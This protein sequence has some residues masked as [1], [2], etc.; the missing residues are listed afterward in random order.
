MLCLGPF[1]G[2]FR[3]ELGDSSDEEDDESNMRARPKKKKRNQRPKKGGSNAS[4]NILWAAYLSQTRMEVQ[5]RG[6]TQMIQVTQLQVE[7][8]Q[9]LTE[10]ML[11]RVNQLN[12]VYVIEI[13]KCGL[14][15][16]PPS[17]DELENLLVVNLSN[18]QIRK[19]APEL[20]LSTTLEKIV[21]DGNHIQDIPPGIFSGERF[22]NLQVISLSRNRLTALPNDFP[23]TSRPLNLKYV[24]LSRNALKSVPERLMKCRNL[25]ELNLSHNKLRQL[26]ES[27]ELDKLKLLFLSFNEISKLP[28]E[29]GR[30]T[31]MTKLRIVD[32]K[33]REL[34]LSILKLWKK[35]NGKLEELL[36]DRNP[37]SMPSITAFTMEGGASGMDRALHLLEE[38]KQEVEQETNRLKLEAEKA[39]QRAAAAHALDDEIAHQKQLKLEDASEQ[40]EAEEES[41]AHKWYFGGEI[42]KSNE[43]M[44][45]RIREAEQAFLVRKRHSY[46]LQ[47]RNQAE[48]LRLNGY[49]LSEEMESF[50]DHKSFENYRGKIPANEVDLFFALFVFAARTAY[51]SAEMW[52]DKFEV[53]GKHYMTKQEWYEMCLHS[54]LDVR[55]KW[56]DMLWAHVYYPSNDRRGISLEDF[57]AVIHIHDIED[58]DPWITRMAGALHLDYYSLTVSDI[59]GRLRSVNGLDAT[60]QTGEGNE[61]DEDFAEFLAS[62]TTGT[63]LKSLRLK[64]SQN[65]QAVVAIDR[66]SIDM[67]ELLRKVSLTA[68]EHELVQ[69]VDERSDAESSSPEMQAHVSDDEVSEVSE[70]DAQAFLEQH[71]EEMEPASSKAGKQEYTRI[72][73]N[74]DG[75]LKQLMQVP[76]GDFFKG[77][78]ERQRKQLQSLRPIVTSHHKQTVKDLG[79]ELVV[80]QALL[81]AFRNMPFFDFMS[82]VGFVL[83]GLHRAQEDK[84]SAT[85]RYWHEDDPTFRHAM[86]NRGGA[87]SRY[88]LNV[89]TAMG[90]VRMSQ[91]YWIWPSVHLTH[92]EK[93]TTWG[94]LAVPPNCP[95]TRQGRLD[96][97]VSLLT[98]CL[99]ALHSQGHHY[100]G[101]FPS[102]SRA[103][104]TT[105]AV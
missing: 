17:L 36:V 83:R 65:K 95:G 5:V 56:M 86:G 24:D 61:H 15:K 94:E 18:N 40:Q 97:M 103:T 3:D 45:G 93:R 11:L 66:D 88:T 76:V 85:A 39:E 104:V 82:F 44:V 90:F 71:A 92:K 43:K 46:L 6:A 32:N 13:V 2:K 30:S 49:H 79:S 8:N 105:V 74:G 67:R 21:L 59:E 80:R 41:A 50:L 77:R 63:L 81:D 1:C 14:D 47:Q 96:E 58:H 84:L 23:E 87:R 73:L 31:G 19:F 22:A 100:N 10:N 62:D 101:K 4:S 55:Q 34:P 26:P 102:S 29:L 70:F 68:H 48:K 75:A 98:S 72:A 99:S 51:E 53:G 89:L 27:Y 42:C 28:K 33:I 20:A 16:I 9:H 57:I 25:E 60:M 64:Q 7:D 78:A 91:V 37:L 54:P 52:Y 35:N 69:D 38:Y 12:Q